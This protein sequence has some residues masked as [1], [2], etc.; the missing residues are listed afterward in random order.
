MKVIKL[1]K[2]KIIVDKIKKAAED[3]STKEFITVENNRYI[4][5]KTLSNRNDLIFT[6]FNISSLKFLMRSLLIT[7]FSVSEEVDRYVL[8]I[9]CDNKSDSQNNESKLFKC[10]SYLTEPFFQIPANMT[11][12]DLQRVDID[13]MISIHKRYIEEMLN[14]IHSNYQGQ[15]A[16]IHSILQ[17]TLLENDLLKK[18][19][20]M[21]MLPSISPSPP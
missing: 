2:I 8:K 9:K 4:F 20:P 19:N 11:G 16:Y 6:N 18:S 5:K 10:L 15:L 7:G 12:D 21:L 17:R 13:S 3:E 14:T 1:D